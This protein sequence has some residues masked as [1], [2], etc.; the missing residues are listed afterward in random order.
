MFSLKHYDKSKFDNYACCEC[1]VG[2]NKF[3]TNNKNMKIDLN[4]IF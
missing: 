1:S 4:D 2:V 3:Y